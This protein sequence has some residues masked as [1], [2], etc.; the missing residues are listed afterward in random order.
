MSLHCVKLD[1]I[2]DLYWRIETETLDDECYIAPDRIISE[3]FVQR[4][5]TSRYK[6]ICENT[7][8]GVT[9]TIIDNRLDFR[10]QDIYNAI[11]WYYRKKDNTSLRDLIN[12]YEQE[13]EM[14][15]YE[16]ILKENNNNNKKETTE[17]TNDNNFLKNMLAKIE[18][19][20]CKLTVKGAIAIQTPNGYKTYNVKT[21]RLT[22]CDNFV[23]DVGDN[24]FFVVPTTKVKKGD[25]ILIN[26]KPKCVTE[27]KNNAVEVINYENSTI[28]TVALE[29]HM[30]MGETYFYGKIVSMFG[31]NLLNG[32]KGTN[33]IFQILMLQEMFGN[34]NNGNMF[35]GNSSNSMS[36][37][38]P[39]LMMGNNGFSDMFEGMFDSDDDEDDNLLASLIDADEEEDTEDETEEA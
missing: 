4:I 25:I 13:H 29:R 39:F 1:K 11:E 28:E 16:E 3:T 23:L 8:A 10:I 35:N 12:K 5:Y 38:L 31:K 33:K 9:V 30:F 24:F 17:M 34:K 7:E 18:G 15:K 19:G 20:K 36:N 37:M 14:T 22:N 26:G 21:G 6:H 32:K 27:V 2:K